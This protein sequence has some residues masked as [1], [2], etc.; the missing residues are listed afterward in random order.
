MMVRVPGRP[1]AIRV[2]TEEERTEA[3]NYATETGGTVVELPLGG[4]DA[5]LPGSQYGTSDRCP[6][7][8]QL[9]SKD[10]GGEH[11]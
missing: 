6:D 4:P 1:A 2:F 5:S 7:H 10:I 9:R 8:P 3:N 11:E